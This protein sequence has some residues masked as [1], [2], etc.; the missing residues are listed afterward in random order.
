MGEIHSL[1]LNMKSYQIICSVFF[2][3]IATVSDALIVH[4][5]IQFNMKVHEPQ[6]VFYWLNPVLAPI[7]TGKTVLLLGGGGSGIAGSFFPSLT[8]YAT[9]NFTK[10]VIFPVLLSVELVIVSILS[11]VIYEW[12]AIGYRPF[13][14][15]NLLTHEVV[16]LLGMTLYFFFWIYIGQGVRLTTSSS[17]SFLVVAGIQVCELFSIYPYNSSNGSVPP[18]WI[19]S[20]ACSITFPILDTWYLAF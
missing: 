5:A 15:P 10:N 14:V 20:R 16:M 7:Q 2:L 4:S 1:K 13:K 3:G 6:S 19:E 9:K 12:V 8:D 18:Y 17:L 11:N